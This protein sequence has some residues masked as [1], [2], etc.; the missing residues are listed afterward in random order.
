[1]RK[2]RTTRRHLVGELAASSRPVRRWLLLRG[3]SRLDP[4]LV[5]R[6]HACF[7]GESPADG[8]YAEGLAGATLA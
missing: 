7:S 5:P 1:M 2:R 6:T 8:P 4:N 3:G